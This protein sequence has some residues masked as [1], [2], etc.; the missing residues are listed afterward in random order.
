L[1]SFIA[2]LVILPKFRAS[3]P[4]TRGSKIKAEVSLGLPLGIHTSLPH[5]PA[6]LGS[7]AVC[8]ADFSEVLGN[9]SAV[10]LGLSVAD[11]VEVHHL[12]HFL[13]FFVP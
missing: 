5:A 13:S 4:W 2:E 12:F 8:I 9:S 7:P 1:L 11:F 10:L 6:I 3:G